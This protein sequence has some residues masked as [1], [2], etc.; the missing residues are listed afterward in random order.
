MS[1]ELVYLLV[2]VTVISGGRELIIQR[3][4]FHDKDN[5]DEALNDCNESLFEQFCPDQGYASRRPYYKGGK[6]PWNQGFYLGEK[7]TDRVR[8]SS[9]YHTVNKE[10]FRLLMKFI[11]K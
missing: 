8:I 10:E 9:D 1:N 6:Q 2:N 7:D 11:K 5:I 4:A 3:L